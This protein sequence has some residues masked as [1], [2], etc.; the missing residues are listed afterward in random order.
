MDKN[1]KIAALIIP[2]FGK[3]PVWIDLF[4]HSCGKNTAFDF[5]IFSDCEKPEITYDNVFFNKISFQDYCQKVSAELN[6][7]FNP[8]SAYKLCDLKPFYGYIHREDIKSYSFWGFCDVDLVFGNLNA[9]IPENHNRFDVFSTHN[10]RL[11]GH[12]CMIR[13]SEEWV[14]L[15]FMI[16]DWKIKL[17]DNRYFGL[18]ELDFSLLIFPEAKY[19]ARFYGKIMM[20]IMGWK[21]AWE[22]YYTIFPIIHLLLNFKKRRLYF[23]EQHTTPILAADGRLYRKESDSWLYKLGEVINVRHQTKQMY[24]HFMVFKKNLYSGGQYWH[25]DYYHLPENYTFDDGIV[26]D[27]TGFK[28]TK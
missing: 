10:D 9:F 2:Y 15:C 17:T 13:N 3:W 6:I 23:R 16:D 18:D 1:L 21:L 25:S 5:Y 8:E 12:F 4:L 26:I 27:K 22:T 19:I 24:L 7:K 20:K 11:S 14:R 28:P